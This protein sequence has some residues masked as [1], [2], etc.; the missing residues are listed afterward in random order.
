MVLKPSSIKLILTFSALLGAANLLH[1]QY[2]FRHLNHLQAV[3]QDAPLYQKEIDFHTSVRPLSLPGVDSTVERDL[4]RPQAPNAGWLKRKMFYEDL[5]HF[6][7]PSFALTFNPVVNFQLGAERGADDYRYI[8]TRG[9]LVDGRIGS[10]FT[11]YTS[12]LENQGRFADYF[13]AYASKRRVV[14]GQGSSVRGFGEGGF[15]YGLAAAEISYNPNRFF[16]F[17]LGQGRN[18]FGEGYR[19]MLLSDAAFTYPFFRIETTFWKI[20]YV[21][22]WAEMNDIRP[23]VSRRYGDVVFAKKYLSAHYFSLN[24]NSRLNLSFFEA[25]ILGDSAQERGIDVAF[26]NPVIF[27]RPVEFAVGSGRGNAIIGMN[28]SYKLRDYTQVYGQ[29]VLDEFSIEDITASNG[30]WVNKFAWQLGLKQYNSF[31]VEG[32]FTRLEYNASRPYTYTHREVLTNYA[33]Y[34]TALAHPWESNFHELLFQV[35]YQHKR[36][37]Y[38]AQFTYG[39]RGLDANNNNWGGDIYLPYASRERDNGNFIGQGLRSDFFFTQLRCAWLANPQ[40]NLKV[41]LGLRYRS[42]EALNAD[43]T[44]TTSPFIQSNTLWLFA[45]IRTELFNQYYDF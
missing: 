29:F 13:T 27:Y 26:F 11:F 5:V 4:F 40:T 6:E 28:V 15:D 36:W 18:F 10:Q 24:I 42:L 25:I 31:A 23:S 17:T 2:Q 21:N 22:L 44:T 7:K 16:T 41:E 12:F 43:E 9:F 39:R 33:H 20:K 34:G 32:L 38:D 45:G 35:I 19:S 8:N 37:E 3:R 1:G 30:S 14:P